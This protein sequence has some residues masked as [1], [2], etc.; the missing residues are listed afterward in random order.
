MS[1]SLISWLVIGFSAGSII[2]NIVFTIVYLVNS[3]KQARA[4]RKLAKIQ[5]VEQEKRDRELFA[6]FKKQLHAKKDSK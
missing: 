6:E 1:Q 4:A 2:L 3:T 5:K